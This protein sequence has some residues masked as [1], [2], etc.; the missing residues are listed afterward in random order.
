MRTSF[1]R[2]IPVY[3]VLLVVMIGFLFPLAILLINVFKSNAEVANSPIALP[4]SIN[5]E[6]FGTVIND[7]HY[8]NCLLNTLIIS[9]IS[10]V[11][12][13]LLSSMTAYYFVRNNT[14][15]NK[16]LF[17]L[18]V[19]SMIIPFQTVMI[20]LVSIYG[21]ALGWIQAQPILTLIFMYI[22]FG[23]PLAVF[24]YHGSIK[25]IPRELDEAAKVDGCN[26]IQI[27]FRIILQIL[28]PTTIT[29]GI[30]DF[31]WIWNDYLLPVLILQNA[32][33]KNMTLTISIRFFR[34]D[35]TIDYERF[36]P[37]VLLVIIIPLLVYIFTQR[38]I[39]KGIT[40]GSIK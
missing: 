27:F 18:M 35:Y 24:I 38:Y 3:I 12:I 29:I 19:A 10:L 4:D 31:L 5:L 6:K 1:I 28:K 8:F 32:G 36:L 16:F 37:A 2:K 40:E 30:L 21:K 17:F 34:G 13:I 23:G 14:K 7:M 15:T 39:I 33:P 9:A 20:P 11:F 25:S 22:G 26:Q